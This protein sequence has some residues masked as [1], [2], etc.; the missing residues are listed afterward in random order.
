M[1]S[2]TKN[3]I[4]NLVTGVKMELDHVRLIELVAPWNQEKQNAEAFAE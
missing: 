3:S 4:K 1:N 2:Q